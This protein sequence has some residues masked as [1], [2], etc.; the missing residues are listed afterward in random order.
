[1]EEKHTYFKK[2][3]TLI[4]ITYMFS[5]DTHTFVC[6]YSV[7][8]TYTLFYLAR[9]HSFIMHC[10]L[11][12]MHFVRNKRKKPFEKKK[13]T[14]TCLNALHIHNTIWTLKHV[15]ER[16]RM[17]NVLK[18]I[19]CTLSVWAFLHQRSTYFF[20][21]SKNTQVN[22]K[23]CTHKSFSHCFVRCHPFP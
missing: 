12:H 13:Q 1:M 11:C 23:K 22:K 20:F 8:C 17:K 5:H 3:I 4:S 15:C 16:I 2:S 6:Q 14:Y 7:F 18:Y 9:M 10:F 19:T 21:R